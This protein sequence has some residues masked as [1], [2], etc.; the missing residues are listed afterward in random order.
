[1]LRNNL[2]DFFARL[3]PNH[4]LLELSALEQEE[5]RNAADAV[6]RGRLHVLVHVHLGHFEFILMRLGNILD[7]WRYHPAG[8]A[9]LSPKIDQHREGAFQ[10]F[11]LEIGV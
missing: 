2:D 8:H 1:M 10:N 3:N 9:P 7:S 5:S 11:I 4:G 6:F